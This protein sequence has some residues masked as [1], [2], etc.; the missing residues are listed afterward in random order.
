MK[1]G[2]Y[3]HRPGLSS[4][5]VDGDLGFF[6]LGMRQQYARFATFHPALTESFV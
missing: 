4:M 6:V 2:P 3:R 1:V 5:M